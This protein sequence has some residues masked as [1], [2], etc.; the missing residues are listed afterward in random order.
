ML[1]ALD[2]HR[3]WIAEQVLAVEIRVWRPKPAGAGWHP[4]AL[5]DEIQVAVRSS[6][7]HP[8]EWSGR[9]VE[10]RPYSWSVRLG[11]I[12]P[13]DAVPGDTELL[14]LAGDP[15]LPAA[16]CSSPRRRLQLRRPVSASSRTARRRLSRLKT[17]RVTP[18]RPRNK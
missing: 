15:W 8:P 4:A 18:A 10:T 6:G 13:T 1:A 12:R 17:I 7:C 14:G 11:G 5:G 3:D 2:A 16:R 9:P